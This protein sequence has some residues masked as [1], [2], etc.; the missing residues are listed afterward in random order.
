M[1]SSWIW[2]SRLTCFSSGWPRPSQICHWTLLDLLD[3]SMHFFGVPA[4]QTIRRWPPRHQQHPQRKY[5][6]VTST[7]KF[8]RGCSTL[9]WAGSTAFKCIICSAFFI[10]FWYDQSAKRVLVLKARIYLESIALT[11]EV[12]VGGAKIIQRVLNVFKGL[13]STTWGAMRPIP[14]LRT[15]F[16][17]HVCRSRFRFTCWTWGKLIERWQTLRWI[18]RCFSFHFWL[19]NNPRYGIL[20]NTHVFKVL[21]CDTATEPRQG[22][23]APGRPTWQ[24]CADHQ[25]QLGRFRWSTMVPGFCFLAR[26]KMKCQMRGVVISRVFLYY[27]IRYTGN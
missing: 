25:R 7:F 13:I 18:Q 2:V 8:R 22:T 24:G 27:K 15:S 26:F 20:K 11:I 3:H 23:E 4:R 14:C 9:G 5:F 17:F 16:A 21:Q 6:H 12:G 1:V 10:E 19:K